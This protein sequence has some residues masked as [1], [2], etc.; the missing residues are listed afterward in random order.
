MSE[1]RSRSIMHLKAMQWLSVEHALAAGRGVCRIKEYSITDGSKSP[2]SESFSR[3]PTDVKEAN[4]YSH[5]DYAG[6]ADAI[7][8]TTTT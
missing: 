7:S 6:L 8:S 2:S 1:G 3:A 5:T 4:L